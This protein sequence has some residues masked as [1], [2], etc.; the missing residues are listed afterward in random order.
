M[1]AI[2]RSRPNSVDSVEPTNMRAMHART[3]DASSAATPHMGRCEFDL[4]TVVRTH[5]QAKYSRRF[6]AAY[7]HHR[8]RARAPHLSPGTRSPTPRTHKLQDAGYP[9][10]VTSV[11]N[12][13]NSHNQAILDFP[14]EG[15][16]NSNCTGPRD[17]HRHHE[18][19]RH[20]GPDTCAKMCS[21]AD[22]SAEVTEPMNPGCEHFPHHRFFPST[23]RLYHD[24]YLSAYRQKNSTHGA[25]Q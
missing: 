8:S 12:P 7:G 17:E 24:R 16:P 21:V 20:S 4:R 2:E 3:L 5:A 1:N 22:P 23:H 13:S 14:T 18:H 19:L 25:F 9:L 15:P 10:A 6:R 11:A